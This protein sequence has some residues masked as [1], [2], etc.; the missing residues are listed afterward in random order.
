MFP[1]YLK[2][3]EFTQPDEPIYYL[4]AANG[5]FLVKNHRLF[6]SRTKAGEIPW[7]EPEQEMF[8]FT[9]PKLPG[10]IM[11]QALALFTRVWEAHAAEC[12]A[13]LY[14]NE[15]AKSYRLLVPDQQVGGVHCIYREPIPDGG[16]DLRAGT[17]HSH[18]KESAFVSDR[19]QTD[20]RF[21]DGIHLIVGTIDRTPSFHASA[22]ADGVRFSLEPDQIMDRLPA[23]RDIAAWR[24]WAEQQLQRHITPLKKPIHYGT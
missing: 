4:V 2:D 15:D 13:L 20:E 7:L 17:I 12:V 1:V 23:D 24:S 3:H 9:G 5:V 11:A 21:Q 6:H 18:A 10:E 22:I 16:D 14:Y 19:D 8:R